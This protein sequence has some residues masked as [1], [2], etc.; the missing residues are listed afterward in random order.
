MRLAHLG[1]PPNTLV[2]IEVVEYAS[3]EALAAA[4][5]PMELAGATVW[6]VPILEMTPG[7]TTATE[8]KY[9]K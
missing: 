5:Y 3:N 9:R 2:T 8:K 6:A 4:Q 1:V 7:R